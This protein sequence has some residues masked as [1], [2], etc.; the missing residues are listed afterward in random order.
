MAVESVTVLHRQG[1]RERGPSRLSAVA[2][3]GL[4]PTIVARRGGI[5]SGR[6]DRGVRQHQG[7]T[8][9]ARGLA[10]PVAAAGVTRLGL[11]LTIAAGRDGI[12]FGRP[13]RGVRQRDIVGPLPGATASTR[14]HAAIRSRCGPPAIGPARPS[15]RSTHRDR[16]KP[17]YCCAL[18]GLFPTAGPPTWGVAPSFKCCALS[19]RA[20]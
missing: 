14:R 11:V 4:A 2:G 8:R 10:R 9:T 3:F 7:T 19:G 12:V 13:D 16:T 15:R 1:G 5:A 17:R 18:T 6:V 20:E